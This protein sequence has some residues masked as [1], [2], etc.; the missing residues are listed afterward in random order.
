MFKKIFLIITPIIAIIVLIFVFGVNS[1]KSSYS[2]FQKDG[3]VINT[4][5]QKKVYFSENDNY[6][7]VD[8]SGY[9]ELNSDD[10]KNNKVSEASFVH[11]VDGSISTF[12]KAVFLDLDTMNKDTFQYYNIFPS[13][14]ISN[15]SDGYRINYLDTGIS[16]KNMLMKISSNKYLI[17]AENMELV[18]KNGDVKKLENSYLE[19]TYLDG[20]IIRLDN[21]EISLQSVANELQININ[22]DISL[23]LVNRKIFYKKEEKL[24]LGEITINSDDNIDIIQSEDNTVIIEE[25]K[26]EKEINKNLPKV[27]DGKI[28]VKQN[29]GV[30]EIVDDNAK[31][32]EAVFDVLDFETNA[33]S[34]KA[35]IQIDDVDG[36]LSGSKTVKIIKT[37]TNEIVYYEND[38]TGKTSLFVDVENLKPDTNYTLIVNQ[39]YMKNDVSFNRD[40][41]QK[42]FVTSPLGI[43]IEK[44]YLREN[45]L[46]VIVSK[47]SF[48]NVARLDYVLLTADGSIVNSG[49]IDFEFNDSVSLDFSDLTSNTKYIFKAY[50]FVYGNMMISDEINE[51]CTLTTLKVKP[52]V[53]KASFSVDKQNSKFS[54]F[55]SNVRDDDNGVISFRTDVYDLEGSLVVT[56]SA[57]PTSKIDIPVDDTLIT[58]HTDYRAYVTLIFNDNEKVYEIPI[59]SDTLNINSSNHGPIV[60]FKE[61]EITWESIKGNIFIKDVD[62]AIDNTQDLIITY[63]NLTISTDPVIL[64]RHN[65]EKT[66]DEE[67]ILPVDVNNLKSNDTYLFTVKAT[68]DYND[69][70]GYVL[71]DI[72]QFLVRTGMPRKMTAEFVDSGSKTEAFDIKLKLRNNSASE[73]T[74]LEAST[75]S[76]V[77]LML[78]KS[79]YDKSTPC[80]STNECWKKTLYDEN[81]EAYKSTLSDMLYFPNTNEYFDVTPS[82]L[83][84]Q[85]DDLSYAIYNLEITDAKDYTVYHNDLPIVNNTFSITPS[86]VQEQVI[87]NN[88]PLSIKP[89]LNENTNPSLKKDTVIGYILTPNLILSPET[90]LV[91]LVFYVYDFTIQR[92]IL[93]QTKVP[94]SNTDSA[95]DIYF[96]DDT[97]K[98]GGKYY[99]IFT[100]EVTKNGE[101]HIYESVASQEVAPLREVPTIKYYLSHRELDKSYWKYIFKDVDDALLNNS[102]YYYFGTNEEAGIPIEKNKTDYKTLEI[103]TVYGRLSVFHYLSLNDSEDP[104]RTD[105]ISFYFAP[106]INS[107]VDVNYSIS[108]NVNVAT[109][110]FD[111]DDSIKNNVLLADITLTADNETVILSKLPVEE[112]KVTVE[113]GKI[114][115]LK[116]K[117]DITSKIKLYFD[118]N[119]Y[120]L[121]MNG[122][123]VIQDSQEQYIYDND[124]IMMTYDS[125]NPNT[126]AITYLVGDVRRSLTYIPSN[127]YLVMNTKNVMFKKISISPESKTSCIENCTFSFDTIIPS[128]DLPKSRMTAQLF[129]NAIEPIITSF[130]DEQRD[131]MS[132]NVKVYDKEDDECGL[133]PIITQSYPLTR[134]LEGVTI[135]GLRPNK[136]YCATFTW[137]DNM[138]SDN[139]FYYPNIEAYENVYQLSTLQNVMLSN[140][141]AKYTIYSNITRGRYMKI[142]YHLGVTEGF[143][144]VKYRITDS[145]TGVEKLSIA[146]TSIAEIE[147]SNGNIE[148]LVNISG[149]LTSGVRYKVEVIPFITI[150]GSDE[151]FEHYETSFILKIEE[152]KVVFTRTSDLDSDSFSFKIAI[153]DSNNALNLR[154]YY[155]VYYKPTNSNGEYELVAQNV[156]SSYSKM[157]SIYCPSGDCTVLVSYSADLTN[158]NEYEEF[159]VTNRFDLVQK[160]EL[161]E[162]TIV[163][164]SDTSTIRLGFIGSYNLNAIKKIEY[165]IY[166]FDDNPIIANSLSN[167]AFVTDEDSYSYL[168]LRED[169]QV[170]TYTI[171]IQFQGEDEGIISRSL[172][173][174]KS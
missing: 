125:F 160:F 104:I 21:Q 29:D 91:N 149:I 128:F 56:K 60:T 42:S 121:D 14:I 79:G 13:S 72:G 112:K 76:M 46:G 32:H 51:T 89:I 138:T 80:V 111:L 127:G 82:T 17:A 61:T 135:T 9:V 88:A 167:F 142:T 131:N 40:F 158:T 57:V 120:G 48:S 168:D 35:N 19:I 58:R 65:L 43:N 155:D 145:A 36:I 143:S 86:N 41:V 113:F 47:N 164:S 73:D 161:G 52:I 90:N 70:N 118:T 2:H 10:S 141:D 8:N 1:Y 110:M 50:N 147:E 16:L 103:P 153:R 123:V 84:I 133:I 77:T 98:R 44:D 22:S 37:D 69:D 151:E 115:Q 165:T 171:V 146:P 85:T 105:D 53:G 100:V 139:Y 101:N 95:I 81:D 159:T 109:Y 106:I 11:Y 129:G 83:D 96:N 130:D 12:K 93:E 68:V 74:S 59:G 107:L 169:L 94:T 63:Q 136:L 24:N 71:V 154:R 122:N 137:S 124:N 39:D 173:Y 7:I 26:E 126:N 27:T 45:S 166:D 30:E 5:F 23:D 148:K 116:G 134:M 99:F 119:N 163:Q 33:N 97:F 55:L 108:Q 18:L 92:V 162:V 78:Y 38:I 157:Y 150:D 31:T 102:L 3:Y 34:V 152:P 117:G 67:Y 54:I 20:N 66:G 156:S 132:V 25:K 6:K 4:E 170:G 28:T 64:R 114:R 144:G 75:M 87:N 172:T 15:V 140:L 49:S 62:D 174:I